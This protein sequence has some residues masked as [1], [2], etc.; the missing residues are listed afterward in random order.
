MA[1]G[2]T[3][4]KLDQEGYLAE[5]ADWST[6]VAAELARR[7]DLGPL[8]DDHW[9]IIEFVRRYFAETGSGPPVVKIA[10]ATGLSSGRICELFPCGIAR[11]AYRLAGLPRPEGC[12]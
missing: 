9:R 3:A 11:G 2:T 8:T 5:S 6:K 7:N 12:L 10:R 4:L 1:N